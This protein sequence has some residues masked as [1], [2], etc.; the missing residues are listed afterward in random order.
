VSSVSRANH[1]AGCKIRVPQVAPVQK[2][3]DIK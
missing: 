1:M 3:C 2:K